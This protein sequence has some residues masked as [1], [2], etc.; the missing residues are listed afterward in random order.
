MWTSLMRSSSPW[1][2]G[3]L[4][5]PGEANLQNLANTFGQP[6]MALYGG[7]ALERARVYDT[8]FGGG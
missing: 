5:I 2:M 1:P 4:E 8:A 6:V 3:A 7:P